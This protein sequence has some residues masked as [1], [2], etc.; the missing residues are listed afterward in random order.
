MSSPL[1]PYPASR[2]SSKAPIHVAAIQASPIAY[3]L[4]ATLLKLRS[5]VSTA[6][7]EGAKLAVLPEAFLS[8]YPRNLGFKIG[9]R[10]DEDREWFSKY[11]EVS[12]IAGEQLGE[13]GLMSGAQSSVRIP[14]GAEGLDW[15][16]SGDARVEGTAF[17]AFTEL[18]RIAA[19]SK[20]VSGGASAQ[21][22]TLTRHHFNQHLSVGI[23][24]RS[25]VGSTL[26]CT[27]LLFSDSGVLLCTLSLPDLACEGP[28]TKQASS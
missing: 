15:L 17:S 9:S 16:A 4:P 26:W 6:A 21:R 2:A 27:S 20:I 1:L 25:L 11:V 14:D 12:W 19:D 22:K 13:L 28:R 24:E 3:D 23:I 18:C 8:A 7:N 5:L 10:T